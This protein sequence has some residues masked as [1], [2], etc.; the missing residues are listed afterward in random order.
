MRNGRRR[1][2]R[3]RQLTLSALRLYIVSC[4]KRVV[5]LKKKLK[6]GEVK[7]AKKKAVRERNQVR[8]RAKRARA[9]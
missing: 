2:I 3:R 8:D 4:E 6:T 7:E 1:Y 9:K 5:R